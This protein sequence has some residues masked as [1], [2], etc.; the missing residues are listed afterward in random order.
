MTDPV[1]T[2]YVPAS[3]GLTILNAAG[4]KISKNPYYEALRDGS[5]PAIRVGRKFFIRSDIVS[6]LADQHRS[7]SGENDNGG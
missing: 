2:R 5:I 4:I 1:N 7:P 6:V 3:E